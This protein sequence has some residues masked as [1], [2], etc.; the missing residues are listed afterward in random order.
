MSEKISS[1]KL[2]NIENLN[3][4]NNTLNN[5]INSTSYGTWETNNTKVNNKD[6]ILNFILLVSLNFDRKPNDYNI[7]INS[8][9]EKI[10]FK[11]DVIKNISNNTDFKDTIINLLINFLSNKQLILEKEN[12][13]ILFSIL[14]E[15]INVK[16]IINI[17]NNNKK[18]K[19]Q[20]YYPSLKSYLQIDFLNDLKIEYYNREN[21]ININNKSLTT[22]TTND[23]IKLVTLEYLIKKQYNEKIRN[24]F[25]KKKIV[26]I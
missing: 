15:G 7:L 4:L 19:L 9:I 17:D 23:N 22:N 25:E 11:K 14:N 5:I 8:D 6:I 26:L 21:I 13:N 1:N 16:C 10:R 2:L 24:N 20:L 18:Q 3:I 12:F